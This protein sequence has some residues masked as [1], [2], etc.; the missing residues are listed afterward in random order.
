MK[1]FY[2]KYFLIIPFMLLFVQCQAQT[3]L[4]YPNHLNHLYEEIKILISI[5]TIPNI[6]GQETMMKG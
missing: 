1:Y 3:K 4:S 5:A 6:N 2:K